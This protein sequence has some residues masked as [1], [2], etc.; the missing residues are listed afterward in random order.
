ATPEVVAIVGPA[1]TT[2]PWDPAGRLSLASFAPALGQGGSQPD[3]SKKRPAGV[4]GGPASAAASSAAAS[5]AAASSAA[6]L[7]PLALGIGARLLDQAG[8]TGP[9]TLYAISEDEP[10]AA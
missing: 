10:A 4:A 3:N 7:L 9:R 1:A 8:Y 2:G 6:P 5:S